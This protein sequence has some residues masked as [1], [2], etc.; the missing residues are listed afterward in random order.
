ME[1]K[2]QKDKTND[3]L[4]QMKARN[5]VIRVVWT[6]LVILSVFF[7]YLV[8]Y[9][10][11]VSNNVEVRNTITYTPL[12]VLSRDLSMFETI[13]RTEK[14]K[15]IYHRETKVM[16]II[17]RDHGEME[18]MVNADGTPQLYLQE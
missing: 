15:V 5:T 9:T 3:Y 18:V 16:Y 7:G 2:K 6:I 17:M 11:A 4:A 10:H 1:T 14:W 12:N 8:G 13:E